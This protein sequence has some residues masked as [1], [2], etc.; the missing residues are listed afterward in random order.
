MQQ[1]DQ[2]KLFYERFWALHSNALLVEVFKRHGI[3]VFRRS[4]VLEGLEKILTDNGVVGKRCLEIGTCNG[5]TAIVMSQFFGEVVTI[6]ISANPIKHV[7]AHDLGIKNI[8]FIDIRNNDEKV[9]VIQ[10]IS[11]FDFAYVDG[12]HARDTKTDFALVQKCGRV[13][14][15]EYWEAQPD[16]VEL[17]DSLP[18]TKKFEGKLALWIA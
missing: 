15:H 16:V 8:Q 3:G 12:D 4:S 11:S 13:L 18:G 17:V 14:F 6:D 10:Q 7:I 5:L 1:L 2:E 9:R